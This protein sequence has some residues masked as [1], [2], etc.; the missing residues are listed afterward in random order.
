M[1]DLERLTGRIAFGSVNAREMLQLA[2]SLGAIPDILNSLLETNNPHLQNFAKQIDPLK[3]IH[4]LIV[5]TIVDNP[6]LL[7]TEGGLIREG[8]SDQLDRYRDA[9]NNGKKWLSEMESHEREVTGINNLKVGYN[10]VFGYYIE[11]TNSNKDK[12][13][14]DR[15]TRKQTLTN[16]ERYITPDLKEHESLI[17]EAEAK[18][19]GLEYDLFVK[20]RE[21]VKK[22]IP[23]L[24]KLAKQVAS[25]DVLTN[26]ATVSE[27]NNYVRPDFT[28]DKQ[29]INVVNGR[30]PVVEQVMTAGSYIP[31]DV[32]MDQDTDIFLI[33]GP[34]MS[35]KSTYM[36]QMAL[37]AI[38]AQIGCFVPADSA[39]LPIFDQIFTRIG[40]A[41]DLISGQSTFM[42]EMSEA[43]DALQHATKRSLVLFDEIG[44]GTATYDGMALAGAIVKYL[45][46]KVGAKTL[47]ATHYHEL[48][49]LDQTLKHLKNIHVG[50]TEE[51]G[52]LIFLHKIL[53]GPAD[54]SYGIHVAQLAGL[55][56]NVLREATTMLKRLEKQGAGELQP[57]SEQLDLFTAEEASVPA[58]SDDEKD[59]LDDIQNVYLADKTP[60]QVMELVAQ[61]QQELKDKD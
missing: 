42:V 19:T 40:A 46:D 10:K 33:T 36:R 28:V 11:V 52:K 5:N 61:W 21:N 37:I 18:S 22:Y 41:D 23:A 34:N 17:L 16:A 27:Q 44:R 6:P 57:A 7:T 25:L 29:E 54:Q 9:M 3:G 48:T 47:F 14:T 13:P 39:T 30:H 20:L 4:D 1:Y 31:N 58:I 50:A 26:F 55:P 60:L 51:N 12:V 38:M 45:H 49:D 15:Y 35:G 56:H 59:V 32:K 43:N 24:Q 2:H 53:P 8:V